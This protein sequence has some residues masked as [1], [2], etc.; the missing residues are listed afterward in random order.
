[1]VT[2]RDIKR[3]AHRLQGGY[4]WESNNL[5]R[6]SKVSSPYLIVTRSTGTAW[7]SSMH[8]YKT[9]KTQYTFLICRENII[10]VIRDSTSPS[11]ILNIND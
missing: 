3:P 1:M 11:V 7:C 2:Q 4:T 5:L 6:T 10:L 9:V 8:K